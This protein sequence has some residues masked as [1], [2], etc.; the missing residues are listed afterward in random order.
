MAT[1]P[2][3]PFRSSFKLCDYRRRT[4]PHTLTRAPN[5]VLPVVIALV[6]MTLCLLQRLGPKQQQHQSTNHHHHHRHV[7]FTC[8]SLVPPYPRQ[9]HHRTIVYPNNRKISN[10]SPLESSFAEFS[11]PRTTRTSTTMFGV[12]LDPPSSSSLSS[13][14]FFP[15]EK[16]SSDFEHD[17]TTSNGDETSS[18]SSSSW[19]PA[20]NGGFFAN[21]PYPIR[22][23]SRQKQQQQQKKMRRPSP[24]HL[25]QGLNLQEEHKAPTN[26]TPWATNKFVPATEAKKF[27]I[28]QVTDL[29]QYKKEVVDV[30]PN[31]FKFVVVRFYAP[32][33]KACRAIE[34][35]FRRLASHPDFTTV[36]F[37]E[38]PV[39]KDNAYLH[40]GLGIPSLPFAHIYQ[41]SNDVT[42]NPGNLTSTTT[43]TTTMLLEEMKINK[44]VFSNFQRTL[45]DYVMG[46]CSIVYDENDMVLPESSSSHTTT[47]T[48]EEE[49]DVVA[50]PVGV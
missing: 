21:I 31:T 14:S 41:T 12:V 4:H 35:P 10:G 25:S 2:T 44:H 11:A 23:L 26:R 50:V 42:T 47:T 8:E 37:V 13:S 22:L 3:L 48:K 6:M 43:T 32:W 33:C 9:H 16:K 29:I 49:D 30:A 38:V 17:D 34:R 5:P 7:Y 39:T 24:S 36:K 27:A 28:P 15:R 1:R 19:I 45:H 20:A 40:Q 18:S 46:V